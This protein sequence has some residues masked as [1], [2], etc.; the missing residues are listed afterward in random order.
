[1]LLFL[2]IG[3]G[4]MLGQIKIHGFKLGV[5]GVLFAG[6]FFGGWAPNG[7]EPMTI[8]HQ[9]M[10]IGLILFV[11]TVG[12]TSGSGFFASLKSHG[13]RFNIA[14]VVALT[15]GA[16]TTVV[17]GLWMNLEPGQIAGVFCGGHTNTPALA[18]VTELMS[19]TGLGDPRNP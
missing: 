16:A 6:L 1:M 9:V 2:V 4:F 3:I 19:N 5:A 18:S 13:L 15:V 8:A 11:Y 10:Q 12:L 17:V 7:T 14:L